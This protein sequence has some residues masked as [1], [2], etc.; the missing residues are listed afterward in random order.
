MWPM[1]NKTEAELAAIRNRQAAEL[2]ARAQVEAQ[3]WQWQMQR[4]QQERDEQERT[5]P[6]KV[7]PRI[8]QK[9]DAILDLLNAA[10]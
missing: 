9:L 7:L 1:L 2:E 3:I 6:K 5:D 4:Q 10:D 8:E